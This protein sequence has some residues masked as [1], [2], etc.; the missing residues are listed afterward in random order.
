M[1]DCYLTVGQLRKQL[2]GLPDDMP[3]YYQRI[4]DHFFDESNWK[5]ESLLWE[6]SKAQEK[7]RKDYPDECWDVIDGQLYFR[8]MS[9]YIRAFSSYKHYEEDYFVINAHY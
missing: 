1:K 7:Y 2:E 6:R 4:E 9:D 5:T 8:D 3:V